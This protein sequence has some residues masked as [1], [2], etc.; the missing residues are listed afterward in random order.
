MLSITSPYNRPNVAKMTTY[1]PSLTLPSYILANP[2]YATL[3]PIAAGTAVGFSTRPSETQKTYLALRQPPF[4]PPPWVFGPAWTVLYGLMGFASYR[5][6]TN[7]IN[8]FD[9]QKVKLAKVRT[10]YESNVEEEHGLLH[11]SA[12]SVD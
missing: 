4:R 10:S 6:W 9:V 3:L 7:G 11:S 8:S 5:V 2:T 12:G 1:I